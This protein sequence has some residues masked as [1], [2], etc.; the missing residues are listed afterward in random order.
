MILL[1]KMGDYS[2][3]LPQVFKVLK[4]ITLYSLSTTNK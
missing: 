3:S 4:N 1:L 2:L